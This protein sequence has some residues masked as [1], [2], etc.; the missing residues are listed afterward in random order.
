MEDAKSNEIHKQIHHFFNF[1]AKEKREI[2]TRRDENKINLFLQIFK[3]RI[4]IE[5]S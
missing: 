3:P 1:L 4:V 5:G 2:E